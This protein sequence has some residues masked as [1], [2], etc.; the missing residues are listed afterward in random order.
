MRSAAAAKTA[1]EKPATAEKPETPAPQRRF[2]PK[3]AKLHPGDAAAVLLSLR[4]GGVDRVAELA[5]LT[6]I[7]VK[8]AETLLCLGLAVLTAWGWGEKDLCKRYKL[9]PQQVQQALRACPT[10][11]LAQSV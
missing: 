4:E 6:D 3:L 5:K 2:I 10:E 11:L 7:S 8:Q 1:N 9:T